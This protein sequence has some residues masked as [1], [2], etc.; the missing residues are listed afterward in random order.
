MGSE[1]TVK[2]YV[3]GLFFGLALGVC[4]LLVIGIILVIRNRKKASELKRWEDR[5]SLLRRLEQLDL[6][7]AWWTLQE[8]LLIDVASGGPSGLKIRI[9]KPMIA[10][11]DPTV[12]GKAMGSAC[13]HL[14]EGCQWD[15]PQIEEVL[16]KLAEEICQDHNQGEF[17]S[18]FELKVKSLKEFPSLME[19]LKERESSEEK[20]KAKKVMGEVTT[21]GIEASLHFMRR[22]HER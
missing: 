11:T 4:A 20:A 22:G 12:L 15:K 10:F 16:K 1:A 14:V 7:E 6:R 9:P 8:M 17:V 18:G 19:F 2:I 5:T 3:L 13:R 21:K